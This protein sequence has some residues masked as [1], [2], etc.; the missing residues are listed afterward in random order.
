MKAPTIQRHRDRGLQRSLQTDYILRQGPTGTKQWKLPKDMTTPKKAALKTP[1]TLD[2]ALTDVERLLVALYRTVNPTI[3]Q[4]A[5]GLLWYAYQEPTEPERR[6]QALRYKGAFK[7]LRL[8]DT[9]D[10]TT[11]E[12]IGG[13]R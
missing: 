10:S 9:A 13:V 6:P 8:D 2:V 5:A 7:A 4:R 12:L 1:R 11:E 3:R